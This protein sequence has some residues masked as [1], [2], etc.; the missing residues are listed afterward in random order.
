MEVALSL[1]L[2]IG[3]FLSYVLYA[4]TWSQTR[5][6]TRAEHALRELRATEKSLRK[7]LRERKEA[8]AALVESKEKLLLANYRFRVA[9]EASRS[10][11]YD[12]NLQSDTVVRSDNFSQVLGYG[13]HE[14]AETWEAWKA[15]THPDDF[16]FSKQEA[17]EYLNNLEGDLLEAEYRVRHKDGSYRTLYNRGIILR[18]EQGKARR[19]IG[20]TV[21]VIRDGENG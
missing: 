10:F 3:G 20:Q 21:D 13:A 5:T 8:E 14:I 12:W 9:E 7:S 11:N 16:R 18:D 6:Q 4:I 17:I 19:V 15:L 2:L 1:T